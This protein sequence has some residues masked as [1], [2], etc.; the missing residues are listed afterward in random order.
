MQEDGA[1]LCRAGAIAAFALLAYSVGTMAQL[2]VLGGP[3]ATAAE[4]FGLLRQNKVLGL[5]RLDL[6]TL[7]ALP[8]YYVLILGLFAALRKVHPAF[9]LAG[10]ALAFM[11]VT[12]MLSTPGPLAMLALCDRYEAAISEDAR[13]QLLAAGEALMASDI[14]HGTGAVLGGI[15]A[16]TGAVL[17]SA[18]MLRSAVFGKITAWLGIAMH[19]LDLAHIVAGLVAPPAGFALLAVAGPFYPVWFFLVGRALLRRNNSYPGSSQIR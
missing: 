4:A 2:A 7:T 5:L 1:G 6:P 3:P 14:W 12:L 15:L 18:A 9:A 19:G 8:L 11:G 17:I 13:A 10:T 16:Q